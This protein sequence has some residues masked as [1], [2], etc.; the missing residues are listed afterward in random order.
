M[1]K[2]LAIVILA[3]GKGTRMKS[4]L[5]KVL[6]PVAGKPLLH[7]VLDSAKAAGAARIVVVLSPDANEI[8]ESVKAYCPEAKIA[9]QKQALGTG[10]AVL[11]AEEA[12]AGFKGSL[13]VAY[14]DTPFI[15]YDTFEALAKTVEEGASV[16]VLGFTPKDPTDYG[17]LVKGRKG[18]LESIIETREASEE[19]R[20]ITLCNSG[21]MGLKAPEAWALLKQISPDNSKK[22]YYLTDIVAISRKAKQAAKVVEASGEAEVLGI[23]S[24]AQLAEAERQMQQRLRDHAMARGVRMVDPS[25]VYLMA[26]TQFG[27]DV[28]LQPFVVFGPGVSVGDGVEIR[29][30]SHLESAKIG[31]GSRVGPFARIRPGTVM[32]EEV[33]IGNFVEVKNSKLAKGSKVNHLS[34]VGDSAVGKNSNIGAGVI[35][36]NYDGVSKHK[37]DIGENVFVGSN[38]SLVAPVKIG[39]GAVIAAGSTITK[40]V[41]AHVLVKNKMPQ[42]HEPDGARRLSAKHKKKS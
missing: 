17:R 5:P 25:T 8:E 38:S 11:A 22:E 9:I 37:T 7:Y 29:S 42:D 12:L 32:A 31:K 4:S 28:V 13:L 19:I 20:R 33:H 40:D 26:D 27:Q 6:H 34:Y 41:A 21:V 3:A 18:D 23:N 15:Q 10:H 24:Q 14:G 35:T 30:Y 1:N 2:K 36:C 39:E 16:A